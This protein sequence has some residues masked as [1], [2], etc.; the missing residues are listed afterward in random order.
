MSFYVRERKNVE[1]VKH[2]LR[3][4]SGKIMVRAFSNPTL[5]VTLGF[6]IGIHNE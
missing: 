1:N 2:A 6:G 5:K 3:I 4:F